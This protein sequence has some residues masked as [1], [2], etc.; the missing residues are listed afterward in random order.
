M[1]A[2]LWA[3]K[4]G[5]NGHVF[6]NVVDI[7]EGKLE[8]KVPVRQPIQVISNFEIEAI[9]QDITGAIR[10]FR[11]QYNPFDKIT[12]PRPMPKYLEV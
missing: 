12:D 3:K 7:P 10:V 6:L 9:T 5:N 8:W 2:Q 1:K 11:H 4:L